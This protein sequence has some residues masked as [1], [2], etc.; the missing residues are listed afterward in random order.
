M[1]CNVA[2][3]APPLPDW[4]VEAERYRGAPPSVPRLLPHRASARCRASSSTGR[5]TPFWLAAGPSPRSSAA[6]TWPAG[7]AAVSGEW[8][9][10]RPPPPLR[11]AGPRPQTPRM[12]AVLPAAKHAC[13]LDDPNRA[14]VW[15]TGTRVHRQTGIWG[16]QRTHGDS[17]RIVVFPVSFNVLQQ[18]VCQ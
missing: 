16:L 1:C 3:L 9:G 8:G 12:G 15:D 7:C 17:T 4:P 10:G 6:G 18:R 13:Y 2:P 5:R 14:V 11:C